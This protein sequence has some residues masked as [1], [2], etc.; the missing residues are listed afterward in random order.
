MREYCK[1]IK[2]L[3]ALIIISVIIGSVVSIGY[4][5][6]KYLK[7]GQYTGKNLIEEKNIIEHTEKEVSNDK[8]INKTTVFVKIPKQYVDKLSFR[9]DSD[10]FANINIKV[11]KDNIY[12]VPEEKQITDKIMLGMPRSVV[13]IN[14]KI[15]EVTISYEIE[16][17]STVKLHDFEIKN[18]FSPNPLLAIFVMSVCFVILF[19][20]MYKKENS[21]HPGIATGVCVFVVSSCLL[22][23]LPSYI[24]G[25][26]EQ[27]HFMNVYNMAITQE[28]QV[29]T[30]AEDYL[31]NY[32]YL[33][34]TTCYPA[35]ETVEERYD[36]IRGLEA[37]TNYDGLTKDDYNLQMSSI[38]YIFQAIALKIGYV[39]HLPFYISWLLGKFANVILYTLLIAFSVSIIPIG[40]R[41]LMVIGMLPIMIFQSVSYT[42]DVTVIGFIILALC[43]IIREYVCEE[44][45]FE[46]KWRII[47][48]VALV[49][50]CLPKAVYAPLILS[51]LLLK[52]DKFYS[53]KDCMIFKAIIIVG[54][55]ALLSTFVLPM[56]IAPPAAGDARGGDT[57]GAKQIGYILGQPIAYGVV[58]IKNVFETLADYLLGNSLL[59]NWAYLGIGKLTYCY[60][61]LLIGVTLTDTY[62][63]DRIKNMQLKMKYRI[64]LIIEIIMVVTLI[65]T[66]LYLSFTEV[67]RTVIAGVQARYYLPFLFVIYLCFQ[68]KKIETKIKKEN[69]Q[70]VVMMC[71]SI[72]LFQQMWSMILVSKC[73]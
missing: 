60:S 8:E 67:G 40:K 15:S 36:I 2:K 16:N 47:F 53:K 41:L 42:Y 35:E 10:C 38:G 1:N 17:G 32:A 18:T 50:G 44:Q 23:L 71:S 64:S 28:G 33:I 20:I 22:I 21:T 13:N 30:Q 48:I 70:L 68:S 73:L 49:I 61:A 12:G 6:I 56:L 46:F 58:L 19:L 63:E 62:T 66:A 34:N 57:S 4:A 25:W 45:K 26:D 3:I 55:L 27:I 54:L 31:Y 29:D 52:K 24:N 65:W 59:C 72:L 11:N 7:A 51:G 39:L 14:G 5:G 37:R 9:Y 69:Y 43:I